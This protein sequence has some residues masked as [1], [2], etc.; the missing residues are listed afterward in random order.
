MAHTPIAI[1]NGEDQF[2]FRHTVAITF[3]FNPNYTIPNRNETAQQTGHKHLLCPTNH[4]SY[5]WSTNYNKE[6]RWS[7]KKKSDYYLRK[8]KQTITTIWINRAIVCNFFISN[9]SLSHTHTLRA[10][11]F[12]TIITIITCVIISI[13]FFSLCRW[14][15]F[16][17]VPLCVNW[18]GC[19]ICTNHNRKRFQSE[20]DTATRN[21]TETVTNVLIF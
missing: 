17:F 2:H 18:C 11:C 12:I 20:T 5:E 19:M 9:Q 21:G 4:N 14:I 16:A 8:K 6:E 15:S 7:S 1:I 13:N 3:N 10:L